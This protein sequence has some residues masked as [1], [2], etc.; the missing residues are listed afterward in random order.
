MILPTEIT[1]NL[2]WELTQTRNGRTLGRV[3]GTSKG[4]GGSM[5]IFSKETV[6]MVDTEL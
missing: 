4:M 6:F 5:H 1:F 2:E 3:T